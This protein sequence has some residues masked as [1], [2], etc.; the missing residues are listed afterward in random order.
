VAGFFTREDN[1]MPTICAFD[2]I[3]VEDTRGGDEPV[4]SLDIKV[5]Y[6]L[7]GYSNTHGNTAP[8]GYTLHVQPSSY[9][10]RFTKY[11]PR[12]GVRRFVHE[13]KSNTAGQRR[14]AIAAAEAVLEST[15]EF[16][17]GHNP[18]L[19]MTS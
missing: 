14:K 2:S 4:T 1:T 11:N 16:C 15:V 10:G 5:S 12:E 6:D 19:K 7:G 8:R 18:H 9:D 17:L 13:T 3:P